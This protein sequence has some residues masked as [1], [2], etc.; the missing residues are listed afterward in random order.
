ME[1]R[2]GRNRGNPFWLN[3]HRSDTSA[4]GRRD[5]DDGSPSPSPRRYGP[6]ELQP[7]TAKHAAYRSSVGVCLCRSSGYKYRK[8]MRDCQNA[9]TSWNHT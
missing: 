3:A 6:D 5:A 9:Q 2:N 7:A 4:H 8:T 1:P